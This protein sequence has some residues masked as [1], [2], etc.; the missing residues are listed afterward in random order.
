VRLL[1]WAVIFGSGF[2]VG[3]GV[4]LIAVR[5]GLLQAIHHPERMPVNV[6]NRLKRPL[7]LSDQQVREIQAI[8]R[9]RQQ[10]LEELR[11]RVQ[12]E[13]M[14]ELDLIEQQ[15]AEVLN[16]DQ[17]VTWKKMFDRMRRVWVPPLPPQP[18]SGSE[19][20][21]MSDGNEAAEGGSSDE[22]QNIE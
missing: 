11:G 16:E 3:T 2:F 12:P 18:A 1:L 14:E 19:S 8:L 5:N 10:S 4:T 21:N 17:R 15:I 7:R 22:P 20:G 9:Q 13:L 6:A